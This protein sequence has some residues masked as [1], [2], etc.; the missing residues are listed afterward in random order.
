VAAPSAAIQHLSP[1]PNLG[2][3][4]IVRKTQPLD[5]GY[6]SRLYPLI[7]PISQK[8]AAKGA[9]D[10]SNLRPLVTWPMEQ[11]SIIFVYLQY[12][13]DKISGFCHLTGTLW[14]DP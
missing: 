1:E 6:H 9:L 3:C 14:D 13:P 4:D 5:T 8:S 10:P 7:Q 12:L 11:F 2:H